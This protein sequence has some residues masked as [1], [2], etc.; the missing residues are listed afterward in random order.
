MNTNQHFKLLDLKCKNHDE[1]MQIKITHIRTYSKGVILTIWGNWLLVGN[2]KSIFPCIDARSNG[3]DP[4]K[5][6]LM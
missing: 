1:I 2:L 3:D 5:F 4:E 6:I